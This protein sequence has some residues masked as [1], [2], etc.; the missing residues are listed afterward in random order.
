MCKYLYARRLV[1][2]WEAKCC[3]VIHLRPPNCSEKIEATPVFWHNVHQTTC[4]PGLFKAH[5]KFLS[6]QLVSEWYWFQSASISPTHHH[7]K[8]LSWQWSMAKQDFLTSRF[9]LRLH[10][11]PSQVSE[12]S[13][14][15]FGKK[16][17]FD[18]EH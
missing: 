3:L 18:R 4:L 8:L 15:V 17:Q 6:E 7:H 13:K 2:V 10:I 11:H 16:M 1:G 9:S 14:V 5:R 12:Y